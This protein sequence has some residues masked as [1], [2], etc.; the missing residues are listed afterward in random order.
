MSTQSSS[1]WVQKMGIQGQC[2]GEGCIAET[3]ALA[4]GS[5]MGGPGKGGECMVFQR[6]SKCT[7]R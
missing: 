1:H 6:G 7:A 4:H 5:E 2:Q 3:V